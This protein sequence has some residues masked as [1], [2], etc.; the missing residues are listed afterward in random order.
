MNVWELHANDQKLIN[1]SFVYI[2]QLKDLYLSVPTIG[3]SGAVYGYLTGFWHDVSQYA[4]LPL[5]F[6]PD[7]SKV[8]CYW[9]WCH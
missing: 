8:G 1:D 2:Q 4:G 7:Q 5:F 3:A 6:S 9:L